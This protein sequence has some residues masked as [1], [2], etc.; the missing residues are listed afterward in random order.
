MFFD[1]HLP[2]HLVKFQSQT[3]CGCRAPGPPEDVRFQ[4]F[5]HPEVGSR[6]VAGAG[7]RRWIFRSH[8]AVQVKERSSFERFVVSGRRTA[9]L[10]RLKESTAF[11][12]FF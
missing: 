4:H 5:R 3:V 1:V 2:I 10:F 8:P 11:Q 9:G 7:C 6:F 12:S